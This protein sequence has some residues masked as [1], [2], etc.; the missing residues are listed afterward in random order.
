V[1][2]PSDDDLCIISLCATEGV[3]PASVAMLQRAAQSRGVSL[4]AAMALPVAELEADL[5]LSPPVARAVAGIASPLAAGRALLERLSRMGIRAVTAGDPDYPERLTECLGLYA[6]P[7]LFLA[8]EP[9]LLRRPSLA[10]VGSRRPSN[11]AVEAASS[12]ARQQAATGV[13]IV[14]GG[15]HGIDTAGHVAAARAGGTVVVPALGVAR[16]R[17][18]LPGGAGIAEGH[19]CAVGQFP[20]QSGWRAAQALIRNRTIVAL[21]DAVVAFEPRDSG[22]T[23]HSSITALQMRKPLFLV[24]AAR[25]GA[26]GRGL[27]RLVRQG[28]VAL[29]PRRMPDAPALARLVAEYRPPPSPDQLALFDGAGP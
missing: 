13:T 23:W 25:D 6:P 26:K 4:R 7:V 9:S 2:E 10:I 14:S 20:P 15:A 24:T 19:W 11:A 28:A 27:M 18:P 3:G 12:L 8:G 5:G 21:S 22:G 1:T 29:D 17:W 16:F